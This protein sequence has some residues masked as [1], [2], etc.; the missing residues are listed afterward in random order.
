MEGHFRPA[1]P[2]HEGMPIRMLSRR[3]HTQLLYG[4]PRIPRDHEAL[5]F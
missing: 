2:Q 1:Q 3:H 5:S 4:R